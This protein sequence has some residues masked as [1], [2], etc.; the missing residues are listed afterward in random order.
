METDLVPLE[1]CIQCLASVH[2]SKIKQ[3]R[4]S[5]LANNPWEE[6]SI[7]FCG[8]LPSREYLIVIVDDY[9]RYTD[10]DNVYFGIPEFQTVST[11][12]YFEAMNVK[13]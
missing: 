5:K 13:N 11:G 8:L 10:I 1:F 4:V 7:T 12:L 2:V 9:S 3:V 6:V